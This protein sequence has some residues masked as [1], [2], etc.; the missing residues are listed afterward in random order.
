MVVSGEKWLEH[1]LTVPAL[2]DA[3]VAGCFI[4]S[5]TLHRFPDLDH[6]TVYTMSVFTT[7][8]AF[9]RLEVMPLGMKDRTRVAMFH[10]ERVNEASRAFE[11]SNLSLMEPNT[12]GRHCLDLAKYW[13]DE[14]CGRHQRCRVS[15]TPEQYPTRLLLI[16]SDRVKLVFTR[17]EMPD[18]PYATLS[19]CWG[20]HPIDVLTP[21]NINDLMVGRRIQQLPPSFRDFCEACQHLGIQYVWIDSFCILQGSSPESVRDW[22]RE[23]LLMETVYANS[24]LNIGASQASSSQE[25]CF[26]PRSEFI[27]T[28][29]LH[30]KASKNE[31][32]QMYALTDFYQDRNTAFNNL[33]LF[34]RAWVV[35]ERLLSPRMLHFGKDQLW[36]Q[37]AEAPLLCEQYPGSGWQ[38]TCPSINTLRPAGL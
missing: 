3:A 6:G 28:H 27:R 1:H 2:R 24:L 26:Q 10:L 34:S 4:C 22:E 8:Q 17:D 29:F 14:C 5:G 20:T 13:L 19:H 18:G 37:C 36:W 11:L 9:N 25:G 12:G 23:S 21:S 15:R 16:E 7:R 30:W 32:S 33:H 35:Q 38:L 31:P